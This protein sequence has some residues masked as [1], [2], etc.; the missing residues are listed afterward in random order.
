MNLHLFARVLWR[1]KYVVAAGFAVALL[2]SVLTVAKLPSLKPRTPTLY[3]SS[4][5]LL[6]TQHGFPWGS[7]VQQFTPTGGRQAAVP[8]GDLDRLTALA[9]LY[10][11]LAN[12]DI[13]RRMVAQRAVVAG[14]VA[15][16]QNYSI[17]PSYYSTPLPVL[18]MNGTST[19]PA[20]ALAITQ[21][22]VDALSDYL[23]GEQRSSGIAVVE[24]V[25]VQELQRPRTTSV[26]QG[27]KK[28]L[29][30]AVF[31]TVMLA[32]TG[33]AFVLENLRP[34]VPLMMVA[35]SDAESVTD[36]TRRSA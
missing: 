14:K 33:L 12:S 9:N 1:F 36:R 29:P 15:A 3:G 21:A 23:K 8:A 26:V 13:I 20:N 11:Q 2:L 17:S 24:R 16:T 28:T 5:T 18:T 25:V 22:G 10:V 34:R 7:A 6:I 35:G 31:F 32:V 30:I 4:A 19:T 27:T